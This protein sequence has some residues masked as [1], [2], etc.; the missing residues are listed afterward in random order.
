M[1]FWSNLIGYQAVWFAA[2]IGASHGKAWPGLAACGLFVSWQVLAAEQPMVELRLLAVAVVLGV[3][4]D[5]VLAR[6]DWVSYATPHPALS[7][8]GA[9]AWILV[10]WASFSLTLNRSLAYLKKRLW[11]A[12]LL[13][14][15]GAPLAYLGAQHGWRSVVFQPPSWRG[16]AWIAFSWAIALPLL[17]L[18]ARRWSVAA[19]SSASLVHKGES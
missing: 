2:V 5:G 16:I 11:L 13:G 15:V 12:L 8:H 6:Y 17:A 1:T 14:A 7:P 9:P 3:L 4:I 18:L 10:L 19:L